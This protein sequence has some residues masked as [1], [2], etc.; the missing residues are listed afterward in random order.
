[1]APKKAGT[2]AATSVA[3]PVRRTLIAASSN[4]PAIKAAQTQVMTLLLVPRPRMTMG[5]L[6]GFRWAPAPQ[7]GRACAIVAVRQKRI[8]RRGEFRSSGAFCSR[9]ENI[10]AH[11]QYTVRMREIAEIPDGG[12]ATK[13]IALHL[14]AQFVLQELKLGVGLDPFGQH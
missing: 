10:P 7:E 5:I 2:R 8:R 11:V 14:I 9:R 12:R 6:G 3:P 13:Q 1:M 4:R